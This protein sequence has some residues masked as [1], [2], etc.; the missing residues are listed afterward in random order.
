MSHRVAPAAERDLDDIWYYVAK[1]SASLDIANRL[2][3]E[4]TDRFFLLAGFPHLGRLREEDLGIGFRSFAVGDYVIVYVVE[5]A[6]DVFILRAVHGDAIWRLCSG[7]REGFE[8]T[9]PWLS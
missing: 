4:I 2:V 1:E 5:E 6:G 9:S 3:D 8:L 7:A